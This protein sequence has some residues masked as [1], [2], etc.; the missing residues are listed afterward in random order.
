[1]DVLTA[2]KLCFSTITKS[3]PV[4]RRRPWNTRFNWRGHPATTGELGHGSFV[5]VKAAEGASQF[6]IQDDTSFV[7]F[8]VSW[9]T[10]SV[11]ERIDLLS[12]VDGGKPF[13]RVADFSSKG[14]AP[15]SG[16]LLP[17]AASANEL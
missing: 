10:E 6:S 4:L 16:Y 8:A 2:T 12:S 11:D 1:V 5:R 7:A 13:V 3:I 17:G 15:R 14:R 9:H